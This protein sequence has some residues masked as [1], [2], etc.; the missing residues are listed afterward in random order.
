MTATYDG[1]SETRQRLYEQTKAELTSQQLANSTTYDTSILTLSSAFLGLSIAFIK[2]VIAPISNATWLPLLYLSWI[3]FCLAIVSAIFSFM[4]GQLS[5]K[6]LRTGAERYYIQGDQRAIDMSA[7]IARRIDIANIV[8]GAL[9]MLGTILTLI[10][11]IDNFLRIAAMPAPPAVPSPTEQRGQ[12]TNTFERLPQQPTI[13]PR[14]TPPAP[15]PSTST[16]PSKV[17]S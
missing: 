12:P 2:D 1:S 13:P 6:A 16:P 8:P 14:T 7:A 15:Q 17:G 3:C 10:F 5:Y 4:I 11:V 9:F